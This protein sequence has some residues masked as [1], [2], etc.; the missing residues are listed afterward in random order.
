M[1][2]HVL[3]LKGNPREDQDPHRSWVDT[4]VFPIELEYLECGPIIERNE[5]VLIFEIESVFTMICLPQNQF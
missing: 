3:H 1:Q 4:P 2:L 5:S